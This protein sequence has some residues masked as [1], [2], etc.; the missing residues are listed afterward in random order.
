MRVLAFS[1]G[2]DSLACLHL[3]RDT[4]DCAIFVDTG[5]TFPETKEMVRY[6]E[7]IIPVITVRSD[8]EGQ[9]AREG[10]P[11]DVVPVNW[12]RF[13]QMITGPKPVMVQT[14]VSCCY[15]NLAAPL[16]AKAKE[17][18]ADEIVYGQRDS[19]GHRSTSR[20]GSV[21]EGM[22]RLHPIEDW[23]SRQV[24][25]YL[26]T[27]MAVPPHFHFIQHSS[28]DCYDCPAYAEETKDLVAFT[29]NRYPDFYN[30]YLQR[31]NAVNNAVTEALWGAKA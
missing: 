29:K 28:L 7:T 12:T 17:I 6:A 16:L 21:V 18:G 27:K 23:T 11:A 2:K 26:D 24:L 9:N 25:E 30:E 20:N 3:M 14:Y 4:L 1:G 15:E 5:K 8:R 10:I 13:G 22:V 31:S 19:D